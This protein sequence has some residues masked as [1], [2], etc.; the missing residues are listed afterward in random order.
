MATLGSGIY[1]PSELIG[2]ILWNIQSRKHLINVSLVSHQW[3]SLA[4]PVLWHEVQLM[5]PSQMESFIH[6]VE[7]EAFDSNLRISLHLCLLSVLQSHESDLDH[8]LTVRFQ[9]IIP[10]LISLKH[11]SCYGYFLMNAPFFPTFQQCCPD[12]RSIDF[13]YGGF[14]SLAG[15]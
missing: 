9:Q 4:F 1:I 7:S 2:L 11:L 5:K 10:K 12:L 15:T 6:K 3:Q 14:G 13:D 8:D